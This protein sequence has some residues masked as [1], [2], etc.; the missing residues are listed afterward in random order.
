[1]RHTRPCLG[2]AY[3]DGSGLVVHEFENRFCLAA[4]T[5][6][7]GSVLPR[8]P[9]QY[10][11]LHAFVYSTWVITPHEAA[12]FRIGDTYV[13]EQIADLALAS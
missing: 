12:H 9:R 4:D 6:L 7:S 2:V 5:V 10:D 11:R 3:A 13:D 8:L 1:M